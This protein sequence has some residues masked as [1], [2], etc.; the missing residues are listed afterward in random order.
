MPRIAHERPAA[1]TRQ[2]G[3]PRQQPSRMATPDAWPNGR[4][5]GDE[6]RYQTQLSLR[7]KEPLRER[8][9]CCSCARPNVV[10]NVGVDIGMVIFT[11]CMYV[12]MHACMHACMQDGRYVGWLVVLCC[13]MLF[14]GAYNLSNLSSNPVHPCKSSQLLLEP[15]QHPMD[16]V[17]SRIK[18]TRQGAKPC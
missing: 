16:Y 4:E 10:P 11:V 12:C 18:V 14:Y 8:T 13:S 15:F 9:I 1:H 2:P 5:L 6:L 3:K 7:L 17:L